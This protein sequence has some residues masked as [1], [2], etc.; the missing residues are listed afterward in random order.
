MYHRI[1]EKLTK[2]L[3]PVH[4][5]IRDDSHKHASHSAMRGSSAQETHFHVFV[6][7]EAFDS[8]AL[9]DRHRLVNDILESELKESVHALQIS[10][11][12]P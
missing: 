6:V 3:Q 1:L 4:L 5:E 9:I 11:K 8:K 7:S 10:A 2:E 12:T